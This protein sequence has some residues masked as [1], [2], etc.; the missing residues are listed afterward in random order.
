MSE[1]VACER[2]SSA[3]PG[4]L[5][6]KVAIVTGAGRKRSIGRAIAMAFADQGAAVTLIGTG[7]APETYPEDER[8]S[9]WRDIDSVADDIRDAGG[10]A[11]AMVA[12]IAEADQTAAIIDHAVAAFGRIDILVNNAGAAR[13]NDRARLVDLPFDEW[14]R[15]QR[16]NVDGTFLMCQAAVRRMLLQGGGGCVVNISSIAARMANA[17]TAAYAASKAAMNAMSHA[18]AMEVAKDGIRVNAILPGIIETS[19]VDDLGRGAR[20]ES[21]LRDFSPMGIAGDG[22]DVAGLCVYLCSEQGRFIT[23][24]DIAIDGGSTWH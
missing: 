14:R 3:A 13:G 18:L 11:L 6:G 9:G 5:A 8:D 22:A 10:R 1:S 15:I 17:G 20:W 7:R 19:R 23:G 16:V 21:F 2:V 24:Q 4:V 12:D